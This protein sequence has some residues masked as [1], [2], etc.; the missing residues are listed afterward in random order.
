MQEVVDEA[1]WFVVLEEV[2]SF[3]SE[4]CALS[5]ALGPP[6]NSDDAKTVVPS[7]AWTTTVAADVV[8]AVDMAVTFLAAVAALDRFSRI[9]LFLGRFLSALRGSSLINVF[10]KSSE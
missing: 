4:L 5:L 8:A 7:R 2:V 1:V 6:H 9:F 3:E 10:G